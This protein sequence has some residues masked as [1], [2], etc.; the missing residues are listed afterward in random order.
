MS[1]S[2]RRPRAGGFVVFA[3]LVLPWGCGPATDAPVPSVVA[4]QTPPTPSAIQL[5]EAKVVL[6]EPTVVHFEVRYRFTQ[7]QPD[8][9]YACDIT[10]PGTASH[11]VRLL[12]AWELK[13]EGVIRD[14]VQLSERGVKTFEISISE[15][16]SPRETYRKIS[17]VVRGPVQ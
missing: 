17:N 11:G 15:S 6:L 12:E 3:L 8:K 16:P 7:G 2:F 5:T 10:F 14:K 4:R 13:A 9:Y 1:R